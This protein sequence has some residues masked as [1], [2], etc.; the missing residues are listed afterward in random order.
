[1]RIGK[2]RRLQLEA[3]ARWETRDQ[4]RDQWLPDG[5]RSNTAPGS[6]EDL[7][8]KPYQT[9]YCAWVVVDAVVRQIGGASLRD[10]LIHIFYKGLPQSSF[11]VL[12]PG[13]S[14]APG[15]KAL[16]WNEKALKVVALARVIEALGS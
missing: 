11:F 4:G 14:I 13:E 9:D 12:R 3:W 16:G 1:M 2:E 15:I 7:N 5:F 8:A 6:E 10:L